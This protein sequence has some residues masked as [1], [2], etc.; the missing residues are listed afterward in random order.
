[1]IS[2]FLPAPKVRV[3]RH[4]SPRGLAGRIQQISRRGPSKA[5]AGGRTTMQI[6]IYPSR[7]L[8]RKSYKPMKRFFSYVAQTAA[9]LAEHDDDTRT[10]QL[11]RPE[12]LELLERKEGA[13]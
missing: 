4:V 5:T 6:K 3:T 9:H 7:H 10:P 13:S 8:P 12:Q 11:P 2:L 1:M